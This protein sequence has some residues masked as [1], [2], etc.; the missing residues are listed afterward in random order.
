MLRGKQSLRFG[1]DDKNLA[2]VRWIGDNILPALSS[3][4]KMLAIP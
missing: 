1:R 3:G 2:A 4:G